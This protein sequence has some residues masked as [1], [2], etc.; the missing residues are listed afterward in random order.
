[1]GAGPNHYGQLASKAWLRRR[2][3]PAAGGPL[4]CGVHTFCWAQVHESDS[5][6]PLS[7]QAPES[8]ADWP[9]P[10][11][12]WSSI[13]H[14]P[15]VARQ[16]P[17]AMT[18]VSPHLA[19]TDSQLWPVGGVSV[20]PLLRKGRGAAGGRSVAGSAMPQNSQ[21]RATCIGPQVPRNLSSSGAALVADW[22]ALCKPASSLTHLE[23]AEVLLPW[24][25]EESPSKSSLN[26]TMGLLFS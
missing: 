14:R 2:H 22:R 24:P 4:C 21:V 25:A 12:P 5:G 1:M 10:A 17:P 6:A 19:F 8:C 16:C 15:Q 9:E 13:S 7:A 18:H 11:A 26:G 20:Q 3:H 23:A